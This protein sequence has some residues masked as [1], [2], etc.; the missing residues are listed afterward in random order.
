[1]STHYVDF[2]GKHFTA[3]M[4]STNSGPINGTESSVP[5]RAVQVGRV[6]EVMKVQPMDT[7]WDQLWKEKVTPWDL[8]GVTPVIS[9]LLK[10][11]KIREGK[12]L[13]PGCGG[14][15][16]VV[17]MGSA[18]RRVIGLDISKTA[19]EHAEA[20]AQKSLNAEFV[21]FENAD[22]FSYTPPFKFDFIFDYTFFCALDPSLR[23]KWAEKM[24]ELLALDGE[25]ITLMFPLD[26]HPG[27]PPF[28]VSL[29]AYQQVLSP[30]GFQLVYCNANIPSVEGRAG[31]TRAVGE[32]HF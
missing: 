15:H 23:R 8:Q 11:N 4:S 9:Q 26:D 22:F 18:A 12:V 30:W 27:G 2:M 14:G 25:L 13:V 21:E 16:D 3:N 31:R 29:E 1:M 24:A 6:R 17:A 32:S 7:A 28:S 5:S 19:L 10:D 20:L